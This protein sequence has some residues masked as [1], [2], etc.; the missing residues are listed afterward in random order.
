MKQKALNPV[1]TGCA[2]PY[3]WSG[4]E[5]NHSWSPSADIENVWTFTVSYFMMLLVFKHV[6]LK[7][8][9]DEFESIW[10]EVTVA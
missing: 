6:A 5:A 7:D 2:F 10:N 1:S 4:N 9:A 3:G 8:K